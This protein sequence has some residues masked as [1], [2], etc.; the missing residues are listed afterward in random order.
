MAILVPLLLVSCA[1]GEGDSPQPVP[2]PSPGGSIVKKYRLVAKERIFGF[3][4]QDRYAYCPS[5]LQLG[6]GTTSMFFCGNPVAGIMTDNI[7][8]FSLSQDL[9]RT[10]PASVLQPGAAGTWDNQHTCDPSVIKG[11]F[12]FN[13]TDYRY[14]MFYIGCTVEYYFNEI[15]VAFSNDLNAKEWVKYPDPVVRKTWSH[16]GDQ[17]CGSGLSW[18]VGQPSAISIDK[19]GK[20]LLSYTVGDIEGTRIV[21]REIDMSDMSDLKISAPVAMSRAG[22]LNIGK[23]ALD[24]TCNSDIAFDASSNTILMI[25]PVQPHPSVYPAFI[26]ETLEIDRIG[27]EEFRNGVGTWDPLFRLTPAE[28]GFPRNHN[29]AI[30]RDEYGHLEGSD[31][32]TV[33]YTVSKAAPDVAPSEGMHAEWTY[34]IW[35]A[36]IRYADWA[37]Y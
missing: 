15:G 35:Q 19:G 13:G 28:T 30:A 21:L 32:I 33:Y 29:A 5:A 23:N 4:T 2:S 27:M 7:Y 12:L 24:Y 22:L 11:Q 17:I 25:R 14:A 3:T 34:D 37:V 8:H 36:K 9:S 31:N 1:Q 26:N 18:G 20:I 10:N 16:D 6:D